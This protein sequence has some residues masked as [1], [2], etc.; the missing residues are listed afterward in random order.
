M[1]AIIV[2]LIVVGFLGDKFV[3]YYPFENKIKKHYGEHY[4]PLH[5]EYKDFLRDNPRGW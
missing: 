3:D 5:K 4:E 2:L 1:G